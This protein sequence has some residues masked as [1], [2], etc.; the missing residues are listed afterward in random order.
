MKT[1][2]MPF[3]NLWG[4]ELRLHF[5]FLFLLVF[6]FFT[7]PGVDAHPGRALALVLLIVGSVLLHEIGHILMARARNF[8]LRGVMLLPIGGVHM[9]DGADMDRR[10]NPGDEMFVALAGPPMNLIAAG[11]GVLIALSIK[12]GMA[13]LAAPVIAIDNLIKSFIWVNGVLAVVNLLPAYPLDGG[14]VLRA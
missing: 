2:S 14:R 13:L 8:S 3:G 7:E 5:S 11:I 9:R 4:T 12:P 10:P 6:V 1:W